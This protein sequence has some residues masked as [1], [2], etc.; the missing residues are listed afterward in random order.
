[1]YL[2]VNIYAPNDHYESEAFFNKVKSHTD[3]VI[4]NN[5][6]TNLVI[7]GDYNLIFDPNVDSV[8]RSQSVK[9]KDIVRKIKNMHKI[10]DLTDSYRYSNKYGGFTWGRN[11]PKYM[12]SRLDHIFVPNNMLNQLITSCVTFVLQES[13]HGF[14]FSEFSIDALEYGPGIIRAN[15]Q[16][17]DDPDVQN[18]VLDQLKMDV[19]QSRIN[20]WN[21]HLTLD[22]HKYVL[23]Q[24]LL[25]EGR[26][27]KQQE[28]SAYEHACIEINMLKT[29]LDKELEKYALSKNDGDCDMSRIER[30][31]L[32]I[33]IDI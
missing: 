9:E 8:G 29:E 28:R 11:N 12:R 3:E 25:H 16:L 15:A 26:V 18:R 31:K 30:L 7:S 4:D 19:E 33:E 24:L 23:R 2:F 22:H 27:K 14:L 10:D 1:M 13:D 5:P 17:L 6:G 21:P 20:G 32:A